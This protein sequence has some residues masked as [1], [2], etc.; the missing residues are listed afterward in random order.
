MDL[1]TNRIK[2]IQLNNQNLNFLDLSFNSIKVIE[3]KQFQL[4]INL[5][6][7]NLSSNSIESLQNNLFY[8]LNHLITA[9]LSNNPIID[10][11]LNAF[12]NSFIKMLKLSIAN[13]SETIFNSFKTSLKPKSFK[14]ISNFEYFEATHI[15]NRDYYNCRKTIELMKFKIFYNYFNEHIDMLEVVNSCHNISSTN[16]LNTND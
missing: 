5:I 4:N 10:I 2:S 14:N 15:E 12:N 13:L 11:N 8:G 16:D 1:S 3:S 9:D 7:L 6:E